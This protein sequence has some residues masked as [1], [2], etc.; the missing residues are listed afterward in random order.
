M[1][2][3]QGEQEKSQHIERRY[4][5]ILKSVHHHRVNIVMAEGIRFEQRETRI[6][7]AESEMREV[8]SDKCEHNEPAHHHVTRG[9]RGFYVSPVN[10]ALRSGAAIFDR[11]LNC[12]VNVSD[13]GQEQEG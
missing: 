12:H 3:M 4:I 8:V 2:E 9:K 7:F 5:I 10:V 1:A 6:G 11:Q 13:D